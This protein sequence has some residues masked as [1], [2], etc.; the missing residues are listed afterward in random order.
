MKKSTAL[1]LAFIMCSTVL[2]ADPTE[3]GVPTSPLAIYSGGAAVGVI[4]SINTDLKSE[5]KNFF[6][7]S[8]INDVYVTKMTH[9][10]IDV[11]WLAPRANF[12]T[13]VG[14]DYLLSTSKFRPFVGAGVGVRVFDKKGYSFGDNFGLSATLHAGFIVELSKTVQLR[15]RA[16]FHA[17]LNETRDG[18]AGLDIGLL[19]SKPYRHVKQLNYD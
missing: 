2:G 14:F 18:G 10:F 17:V 11:D 3:S 15:I 19:F 7:L 9:L 13:D 6:K 5:S 12:G 8:F 4:R 1:V 16:P